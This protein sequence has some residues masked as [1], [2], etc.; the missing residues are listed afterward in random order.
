VENELEI[1]L[2]RISQQ[3]IAKAIEAL[4][5]ARLQVTQRSDDF[6]HGGLVD[7]TTR[8]PDKNPRLF[9]EL[10]IGWEFHISEMRLVEITP[11]HDPKRKKPDNRTLVP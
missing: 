10:N 11:L 5:G 4:R 7:H 6:V 1:K 2:G 8:P 9:Y 3:S